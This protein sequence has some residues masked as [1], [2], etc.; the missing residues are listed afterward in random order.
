MALFVV[1]MMASF[2]YAVWMI[3]EQAR[4]DANSDE[5]ID[6]R[7]DQ[8]WE[9]TIHEHPIFEMACEDA[10]SHYINAE[11]S[12]SPDDQGHYGFEVGGRSGGWL[13]LSRVDGVGDNLRWESKVEMED[14]LLDLDDDKLVKLY[15]AVAELDR[16]ITPAEI[17]K[18][19][20]YQ[21]SM[22]RARFEDGWKLEAEDDMEIENDA[23][24]ESP[25]MSI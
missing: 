13:L 22:I 2:N 24:P 23:D 6:D 18:E 25:R 10:L 7:F 8:R 16:R 5:P 4:N 14:F 21:Y 20:E 15:R 11:F 12:T 1:L 3:R 9:E 19:M 17:K